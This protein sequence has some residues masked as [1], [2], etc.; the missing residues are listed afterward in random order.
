MGRFFSGLIKINLIYKQIWIKA[1]L[2][3]SKDILLNF[4]NLKSVKLYF[5]ESHFYKHD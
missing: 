3:F 4:V 5:S 2:Y 1:P